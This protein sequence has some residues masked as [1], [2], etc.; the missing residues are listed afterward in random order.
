MFNTY[1]EMF[2]AGFA[3]MLGLVAMN[4][5]WKTV[6]AQVLSGLA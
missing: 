3:C 5:L 6:F 1:S 2:A 4:W